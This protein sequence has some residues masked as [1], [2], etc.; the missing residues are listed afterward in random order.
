MV[1]GSLIWIAFTVALSV[2]IYQYKG[3]ILALDEHMFVTPY[4]DSTFFEQHLFL[5][6]KIQKKTKPSPDCQEATDQPES[7][8]YICLPMY[9]ESVEEMKTLLESVKEFARIAAEQRD[10]NKYEC[11]IVF[12]NGVQNAKTEK[13]SSQLLELISEKIGKDGA[14]E[15][16]ETEYGW[17]CRW[18]PGFNG[19]PLIVH[20]KDPTKVRKQKRWSQ[21]L[22][23]KLIIEHYLKDQTSMENAYILATDG[24]VSIDYESVDRLIDR[25]KSDKMVGGVCARTHPKGSGILYWY[26]KFDYAIGHWLQKSAEDVLGCVLCCPGCFSLFRC[27]DLNE[28]LDEY[29]KPAKTGI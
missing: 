12:D 26:Q 19:V 1:I 25:L 22:Y 8:V 28:V 7:K 24:D 13:F 9:Q 10:C 14:D 4:Y 23:M 18:K 5:N 27:T 16:Y 3:T 15:K 29:S 20:L 21:V 11:H 17:C 2:Q 6:M